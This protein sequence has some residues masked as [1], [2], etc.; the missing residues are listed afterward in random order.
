MKQKVKH[1]IL[2]LLNTMNKHPSEKH[3]KSFQMTMNNNIQQFKLSMY[4]QTPKFY[5][6][7]NYTYLYTLENEFIE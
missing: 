4:Y 5:C 6:S 3:L 1:L 7:D 2:L